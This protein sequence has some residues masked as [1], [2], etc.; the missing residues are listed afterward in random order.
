M[1]DKYYL[2]K[3]RKLEQKNSAKKDI[4]NIDTIIFTTKLVSYLNHAI[5]EI[6]CSSIADQHIEDD[7]Q[8]TIKLVDEYVPIIIYIGRPHSFNTRII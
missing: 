7:L 1:L 5:N 3:K 6:N 8:L 2:L 4:Q